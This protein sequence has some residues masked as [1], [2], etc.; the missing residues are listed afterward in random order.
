MKP[1]VLLVALLWIGV[2]G[3]FAA[4]AAADADDSL[5]LLTRSR[6]ETP[7]GNRLVGDVAFDEVEPKVRAISPVPGGVGPMT[8]A[9]LLWNT[10][11]AAE[12]ACPT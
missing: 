12:R 6:V 5:T 9:M 3:S 7:E 10:M 2:V 11:T 1:N 8:V 4:A